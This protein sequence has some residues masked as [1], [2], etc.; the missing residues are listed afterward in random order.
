ML[1]IE[2]TV[3]SQQDLEGMRLAGRLA[4]EVLE[5]IAPYVRPGTSTMELNNIC[6]GYIVEQQ[7]AVPAPLNY[8]GFPCSICT[9]PN[10]VVCHG[11]P[12]DRKLRDGDILNVDVTV[13]KDG[14]HGDTSYMF[15][16]GAVAPRTR[17]L[18]EDC[19]QGLCQAIAMVR[20][21]T[22][23]DDIGAAIQQYAEARNYSVVREFCGHGIGRSF[24]TPPEVLHYRPDI[25]SGIVLREGMTFTIEPMINLGKRH[26]QVQHDGWTVVTRDRKPSAQWEHTVLVTAGGCE[27]LTRRT[28]EIFSREE[29]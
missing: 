7:R 8:R 1:D 18:V 3:K 2:I 9:S 26:V 28:D 19:Y 6:H 5:M 20:P 16:V 10:H 15:L 27:V 12:G 17:K 21:G 24:H 4:A 23:L 29:S 13:I 14:W 25:P 11:I 22:L